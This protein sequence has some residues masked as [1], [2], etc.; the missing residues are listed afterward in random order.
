V[1]L[2]RAFGETII[3]L[4]AF[5]VPRGSKESSFRIWQALDSHGSGR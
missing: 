1:Q 3:L 4:F 2:Q 5:P